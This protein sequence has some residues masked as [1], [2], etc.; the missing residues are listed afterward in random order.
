MTNE[1]RAAW[2][3][4]RRTGI[5]GSD[6]A[7]VLGLN[8]WK[9]P[10]DVWNDKLGLSEDKGMSEPAYW[11]TVLEDTVAREFQ[12]RTGMKVQKVTHQFVD[13][14]CD[15]M[16]ANIDR[17]IINREI[18]K[19]VRPLL[20]VEEIERYANITGV[21][22]P[23]NTDIA[24]E[25]KT[26]NA[27]T[28]D[29]W[30]P[31]QELEIRQNNLRTEHVIPLYYETQIQWYCGILKLRGMYLAV[32][33]GGSDF[34][35][36][37]IDARPDVFQVTK[38]KCSAFWNNY[39]LTKTPPEP[40][41]I[42]DVLKL[43]GRS[44][45]KAIEAQ[46]DL[47]INYGEYARL[48]GEIKELKKQQDAVKAKIAIDMKDNEILTLDGKKVLTYKTQTSKRFDSDSFREDH[49]DDYYDYLK[50]SSTRV[51]RVCA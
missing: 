22:R 1:Q 45:G 50:E 37:W 32:L 7:A 13:P 8:P 3:E 51:M 11:G 20:D 42:E 29:L 16:I 40:I 31:S 18:A 19:K 17:A 15:W 28:A 47:A 44:N 10:L 23:I 26:A 24:F 2:L 49:L 5:G 6:V 27:F 36:Y 43:Y 21:E 35:M 14:E 9:T 30:G 38:E 25:A 46:G 39:V 12:Q 33:I 41:N 34:R 4:G 48:N